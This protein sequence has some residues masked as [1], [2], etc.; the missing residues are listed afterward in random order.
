V[1]IDVSVEDYH[2]LVTLVDHDHDGEYLFADDLNYVM[3]D[4]DDDDHHV[5]KM[6]NYENH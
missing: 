6:M 3:I 5:V 4:D 1:L 2:V